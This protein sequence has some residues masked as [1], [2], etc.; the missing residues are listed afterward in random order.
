MN[1]SPLEKSK[2]VFI[3]KKLISFHKGGYNINN[4]FYKNTDEVL[5]DLEYISNYGDITSVR[6]ACTFLDNFYFEHK[7]KKIKI[8]ISDEK[9]TKLLEK[10]K[11]KKYSE[12]VLH[13]KVGKF[14]VTFD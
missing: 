3:C 1:I 4:S 2:I 12:I 10:E 9:K 5:D 14:I 13:K 7:N 8:N 6:R 11:F